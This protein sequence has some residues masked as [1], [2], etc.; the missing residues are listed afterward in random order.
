MEKVENGLFVRVDYKGTL[1]NGEVFDS[2]HGR[3]PLEFKVG[4]GQMIPGFDAAVV[5]MAL[6]EKKTVT[7]APQ[8][9]YG[10]YDENLTR[11]FPRSDVPPEMDPQKGQR[12]GMTTSDGHQVPATITHV[13]DE[14]VTI[15]MNHPLAGE[16][17]TFDIEVVGISDTPV[18]PMAGCGGGCGGDC[19]SDCC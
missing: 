15:D 13:D 3:Q 7:L 5:G 12:V 9:A 16:S 2:S 11:D 18:Q 6:N 10:D 17:L 14:K 19:A 1:Q 8:D 4:G